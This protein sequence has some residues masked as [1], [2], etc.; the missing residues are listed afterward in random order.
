MLRQHLGDEARADHADGDTRQQRH[1]FARRKAQRVHEQRLA[2]RH[3]R[4][5]ERRDDRP[6]QQI[7]EEAHGAP[8][9]RRAKNCQIARAASPATIGSGSEKM[10]R[11]STK[12]GP[13]NGS[14]H[15]IAR[16]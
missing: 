7:D 2:A 5:P 1:E 13:K 14:S 11:H 9:F 10:T 3:N 12:S 4:K 8:A 16:V 6:Q 15:T